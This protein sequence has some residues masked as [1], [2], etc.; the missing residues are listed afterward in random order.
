MAPVIPTNAES[1]AGTLVDESGG[2]F[3]GWLSA[4]LH[5]CLPLL[6]DD[7]DVLV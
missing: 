5:L 4:A 7:I 2:C 1:V 3:N 6:P